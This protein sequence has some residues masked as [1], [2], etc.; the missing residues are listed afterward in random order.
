MDKAFKDILNEKM[1]QGAEE[2]PH[3]LVRPRVDEPH[4]DIP[5]F[6]LNFRL[7]GLK[8]GS[9]Y[10]SPNRP[11]KVHEGVLWS[12][13]QLGASVSPQIVEAFR[14]FHDN[15]ATQLTDKSSPVEL[16]R[17]F[18]KVAKKL[19]PDRHAQAGELTQRR[20]GV[21]FRKLQEHFSALSG[22]LGKAA[23]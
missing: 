14:F 1:G 10:T 12:P 13:S 8:A 2:P 22:F 18:R 17:A 16:K 23:A 6:R 20:M 7:K 21:E 9:G 5:V 15:G 3:R 4:L 19:H 11:E